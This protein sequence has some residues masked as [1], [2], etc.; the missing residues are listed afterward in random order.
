MAS[1]C[2]DFGLHLASAIDN[3]G[4]ICTVFVVVADVVSKFD[5]S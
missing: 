1:F 4:R 5:V 3:N 2:G